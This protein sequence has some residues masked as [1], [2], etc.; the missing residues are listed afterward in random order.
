VLADRAQLESAVANLA[1]NA[2]D[3]LPNGGRL[4]IETADK[5]LDS[6]YVACNSEVTPGDY[7]MLA[8]SDNGTGIAPE[9]LEKVFEPFFTTKA[10][11]QGTGLGLSMVYG[12]AKQSGG[13]VKI[14][15]ELGHGTTVRLYL[16]RADARAA[17]SEA[18]QAAGPEPV[19]GDLR[20][21]IVEDSP[22]VR[23]V[24]V[25]HLVGFG[26]R[27]IQA[28]GGSEALECL[29]SDPTINLLF[30]DVVMPGGMSGPELA[31]RACAA[32]PDLKVLFT[33]GYAEKAIENWPTFGQT[34][35][36]LSKPYRKED[37]ARKLREVFDVK[38]AQP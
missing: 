29:A 37:L 1:I 17:R 13:H 6:D 15:S 24:A 36:L 18:A 10:A 4:T 12:F 32:R 38:D 23:Q 7:V 14:Y 35:N 25:N 3:A 8:V 26:C 27:V 34:G 28:S 22:E 2:R 33:S 5:S 11:R 16:P 31:A 20:I 21:L 30:T 9:V 19:P